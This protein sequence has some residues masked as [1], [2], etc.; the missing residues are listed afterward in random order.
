MG[1]QEMSRMS[2]YRL[3]NFPDTIK[4]IKIDLRGS[5]PSGRRIW[6]YIDL[7]KYSTYAKLMINLSG[8][9]PKE[10][11]I[12]IYNSIKEIIEIKK[13]RN[14]IFH[15]GVIGDSMFFSIFIFSCYLLLRFFNK[16]IIVEAYF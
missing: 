12:G 9:N 8:N 11:V 15:L 1:T 14:K 2:E 6:I 5:E 4:L 10:T 16:Q 7:D 13:N 3:S